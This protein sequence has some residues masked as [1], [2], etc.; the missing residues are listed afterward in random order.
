MIVQQQPGVR[1]QYDAAAS[2]LRAAWVVGQPLEQF[3]PALEALAQLSREQHITRW[4]IDMDHVPPL[5]SA[6]QAW[7]GQEWFAGMARTPV[8]QLAL[9]LPPDMHNYLV[10]TAPVHDASLQPS[11]NLQFFADAVSAFHWVLETVPHRP[12]L[13]A[14]WEQTGV[15]TGTP[16]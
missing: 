10:A 11:F 6:E 14:E 1:I 5:G 9:V 15:G 3:Q 12:A 4:L 8:Q 2:F 16:Q 13:W 7:I